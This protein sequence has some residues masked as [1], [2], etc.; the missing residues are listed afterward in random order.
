MTTF[1]AQ[2]NASAA[3]P[4]YVLA[5]TYNGNTYS[6]LLS[7]TVNIGLDSSDLEATLGTML[8]GLDA[9]LYTDATITKVVNSETTSVLD[10]L[11]P[12]QIL[13]SLDGTNF[14]SSVPSEY[15][16]N[17]R[18]DWSATAKL[19]RQPTSSVTVNLSASGASQFGGF[20]VSSA[21]VSP[22]SLTFTT[23]TWDAPQSLS[24]EINGFG[25]TGSPPW[26]GGGVSLVDAGST[27]ASAGIVFSFG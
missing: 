7:D 24:G 5:F 20:G 6:I 27:F 15:A 18:N 8:N 14:Y 10:T 3:T 22:S 19:S 4:A 21:S 1:G 9:S 17:S 13:V 11:V 16:N 23:S 26:A 2:I 12:P 25:F